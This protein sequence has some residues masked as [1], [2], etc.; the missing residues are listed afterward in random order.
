MLRLWVALFASVILLCSATLVRAAGPAVMV[1][2][3]G[4]D[5][6]VAA[7]DA[8]L[9]DLLG[10]VE[11]EPRLERVAA[12]D[13]RRALTPE[14]GAKEALGRAWIDLRDP[15]HALVL[16]VDGKWDRALLRKLS[17]V[18]KSEEVVR[19]EV[20]HIVVT[21]IETLLAGAE[22]GAP[23]AEAERALGLPSAPPPAPVAPPPTPAPPL[24]TPAEAP[25]E[26]AATSAG[27][28]LGV[29][30]FYE[31]EGYATE[32]VIIHGPGAL[33]EIEAL[34]VTLS[35]GVELTGQ[36]RLPFERV[37]D[38]AGFRLQS[39][40]LRLQARIRPLT[41]S[42]VALH[43]GAGAGV[44][45]L[46][47]EPRLIGGATELTEARTRAAPIVRAT[48]ALRLRLFADVALSLNAGADVDIVGTRYVVVRDGVTEPLLEPLRVRP[49][50]QLGL[51]ATVAGGA[52]FVEEP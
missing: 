19:E 4:A 18:G 16:I 17:R 29:G 15:N 22:I 52:L 48:L 26:A 10:R 21:A 35:P 6:E 28:R 50:L 32:Q 47:I 39:G 12:V 27:W 3:A 51:A 43:M 36:Y 25:V 45:L 9:T 8:T 2:M 38:E 24:M 30:A 33:I 11:V 13:A 5:A 40:A 20:G 34:G 1:R 31:G 44:D 23:R 41:H 14:H 42:V 7:L 46:R 49:W 37:G